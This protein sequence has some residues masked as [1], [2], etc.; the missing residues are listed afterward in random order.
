MAIQSKVQTVKKKV[1]TVSHISLVY[2]LECHKQLCTF[3]AYY[4]F[5]T[6][7]F[8]SAFKQWSDSIAVIS[9]DRPYY[10]K[11]H[12]KKRVYIFKDSV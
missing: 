3:H 7:R 6:L 11:G 10:L 12:E 1:G 8:N 9:M 4:S 5:K 2:T